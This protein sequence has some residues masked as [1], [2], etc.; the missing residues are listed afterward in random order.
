MQ[1]HLVGCI[2]THRN[3]MDGTMNLKLFCVVSESCMFSCN[4]IALG[5]HTHNTSP[6]NF[7]VR[8]YFGSVH[9]LPV[10]MF[11]KYN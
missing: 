6:S 4:R 2:Y 7:H 9:A 10:I 11:Y 1:L 5:P 3:T 8:K